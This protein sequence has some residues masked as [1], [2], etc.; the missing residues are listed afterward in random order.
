MLGLIIA[1]FTLILLH[2]TY[3]ELLFYLIFKYYKEHVAVAG[4]AQWIERKPANQG[5][6]VGFPVRAQAWAAGQ[7]PSRE[8][9]RGNHILMFLS[10]SFSLPFPLSK[11]N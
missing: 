1:R 6:L 3:C 7:V 8:H 9:T 2:S 10:L 5:L 11:N 4:V